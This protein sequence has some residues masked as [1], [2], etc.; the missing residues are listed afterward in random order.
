MLYICSI[1]N[2]HNICKIR[3]IL[4]VFK[5]FPTNENCTQYLEKV[6]WNNEP[7]C[8]YCNTKRKMGKKQKDG[9]YMCH[10]CQKAYRVTV[11]TI[12]HDT[13]TP[14]QKWFLL[15]S[16]VLNAKKGI[17]SCQ[18]ARDCELNQK[19]ANTL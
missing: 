15:I 6:R 12:F 11:G 19:T 2:K 5:T 18:L 10:K 1:F 4:E 13:K 9:H 17:S 16:L 8:P 7:A 3:A 14:L